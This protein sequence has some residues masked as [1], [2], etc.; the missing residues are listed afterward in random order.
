MWIFLGIILF[1]TLLVI[2]FLSLPIYL[3]IKTDN[4]GRII[5]LFKVLHK[6]FG[7]SHTSDGGI[8]KTLKKATGTDKFE[9]KSKKASSFN[10]LIGLIIDVL[11]ELIGLV[12]HCTADKFKLK[13]I[14]A[15]E[16]AATAAISYGACC[17]AVYPLSG[18]LHSAMKIKKSGEDITVDCI[19]QNDKAE[20][21]VE[22]VLSIRVFRVL[23]AALTVLYRE[24]KRRMQ[25]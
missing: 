20:F 13:I 24:I 3:I 22:I 17:A 1:L 15:N 2:L 7:Q 12:K 4:E 16:D 5:F 6:T 23:G 25:K 11:K 14:C 10:D 8:I 21:F 19:Y 18:F 9:E